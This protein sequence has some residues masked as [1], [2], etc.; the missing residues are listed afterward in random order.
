MIEIRVGCVHSPDSNNPFNYSSLSG[1]GAITLSHKGTI[2]VR[3][4]WSLNQ[5]NMLKMDGMIDRQRQTY[6]EI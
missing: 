4:Q 3:L 1:G 5:L 2:S 6:F